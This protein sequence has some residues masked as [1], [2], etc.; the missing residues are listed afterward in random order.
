MKEER[1]RDDGGC[2]VVWSGAVNSESADTPE[3]AEC[4][5]I[6]EKEERAEA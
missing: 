5:E 2:R 1:S 3:R 4:L 6:T